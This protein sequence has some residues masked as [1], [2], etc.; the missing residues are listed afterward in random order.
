MPGETMMH[1]TTVTISLDIEVDVDYDYAEDEGVVIDN[2]KAAFTSPGEYVSA[3]DNAI[4][5]DTI[6]E[7]LTNEI[8][9]DISDRDTDAFITNKRR[10]ER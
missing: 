5:T 9:Q 2:V 6:N 7:L 1:T 3:I 10:D 8:L 4:N